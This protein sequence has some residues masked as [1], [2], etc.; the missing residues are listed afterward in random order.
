MSSWV[1][2]CRY[3][4]A[5]RGWAILNTQQVSKSLRVG[6]EWIGRVSNLQPLSYESD[7]MHA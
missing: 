1:E 5:L 2:L 7:T 3:K 6:M 4:R